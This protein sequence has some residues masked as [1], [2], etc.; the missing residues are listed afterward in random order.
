LYTAWLPASLNG[1]GR[2]TIFCLERVGELGG[3]EQKGELH[4]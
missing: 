3:G 2:I 1:C 4:A